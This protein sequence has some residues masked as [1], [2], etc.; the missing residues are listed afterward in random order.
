MEIL[1]FP[2][3]Y[4]N[5]FYPFLFNHFSGVRCT[6]HNGHRSQPSL[7][8]LNVTLAGFLILV[9]QKFPIFSLKDYLLAGKEE[10]ISMISWSQFFL[11]HSSSCYGVFSILFRNS[12]FLCLNVHSHLLLICGR[13]QI[14]LMLA[15]VW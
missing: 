13:S 6:S 4:E 1:N 7:Y 15:F 3:E 2:D 12:I 8:C 11:F 5:I 14:L 9:V 10:W